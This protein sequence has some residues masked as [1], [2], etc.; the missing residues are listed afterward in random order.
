M[1]DKPLF[2]KTR[3]A[4]CSPEAISQTLERI[5]AL[6]SNAAAAKASCDAFRAKSPDNLPG[7]AVNSLNA[8]AGSDPKWIQSEV[9]ALPDATNAANAAAK[10]RLED[11]LAVQAPSIKNSGAESMKK[12]PANTPAQL[13]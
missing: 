5:G 7:A 6:K 2:E 12:T 11:A 13:Q 1:T 4:S 10:K 3:E 9:L 8:R